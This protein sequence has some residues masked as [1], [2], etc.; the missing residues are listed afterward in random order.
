MPINKGILKHIAKK[1]K[2]SNIQRHLRACPSPSLFGLLLEPV[3]MKKKMLNQGVTA[4]L[5]LL[6][7][8]NY[9]RSAMHTENS[10]L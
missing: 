10:F 6:D 8:Q 1:K 7:A 4:I 2:K 9:D 5:Y 3:E